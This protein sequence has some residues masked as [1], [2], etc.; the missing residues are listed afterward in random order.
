MDE[1]EKSM[2]RIAGMH[3]GKSSGSLEIRATLAKEVIK[4]L[5]EIHN[6]LEEL[7]TT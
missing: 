3:K 2:K 1:L 7:E 6:L 5:D 4:R